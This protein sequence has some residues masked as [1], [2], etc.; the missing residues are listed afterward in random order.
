MVFSDGI[1]DFTMCNPPFYGSREEVAQGAEAKAAAPHSVSLASFILAGWCAEIKNAR[2]G[3][4]GRR[5][6][7]DYTGRRGGVRREDG[8]G[9]HGAEG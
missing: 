4:R 8:R 5:Y 3:L 9:E 6:G 7:D 2:I 1:L